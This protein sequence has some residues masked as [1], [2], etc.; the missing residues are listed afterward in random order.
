M[1]SERINYLNGNTGEIVYS[2]GNMLVCSRDD[3]VNGFAFDYHSDRGRVKFNDILGDDRWKFI[4]VTGWYR[5]DYPLTPD[6]PYPEIQVPFMPNPWEVGQDELFNTLSILHETG[7]AFLYSSAWE[8]FSKEY[9]KF[10]DEPFDLDTHLLGTPFDGLATSE[11]AI[12]PPLPT[13]SGTFVEFFRESRAFLGKYFVKQEFEKFQERYAWAFA[14]WQVL[15]H[16]LLL[17]YDFEDFRH[18]YL[19]RLRSYGSDFTQWPNSERYGKWLSTDP[20]PWF[21]RSERRS[22]KDTREGQEKATDFE[23]LLE[24]I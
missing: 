7:H 19:P 6:S 12:L 4:P 18:C 3:S 24:E 1:I 23:K 22:W 11:S 20:E 21:V 5:V 8:A 2:S 13:L 10:A 9:D 14:L 15:Q 16:D 17:G